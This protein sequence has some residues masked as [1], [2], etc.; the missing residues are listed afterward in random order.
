MLA[1]AADH[2]RRAVADARIEAARGRLG[3]TRAGQYPSVDIGLDTSR[4]LADNG[5]DSLDS[6]IRGSDDRS[7]VVLTARQLL[8][9]GGRHLRPDRR[10]PGPSLRGPQRG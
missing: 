5:I 8:Y 2:P 9:D 6:R 7:D 1:V 10:R 4:R 3:E